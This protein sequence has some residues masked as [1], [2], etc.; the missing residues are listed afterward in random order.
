MLE[1]I[2][3]VDED[4][5]TLYGNDDMKEDIPVNIYVPRNWNIYWVKKLCC[6]NEFMRCLLTTLSFKFIGSKFSNNILQENIYV[7]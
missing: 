5:D 1:Y 7:A 2:S 4:I 3:C 6:C